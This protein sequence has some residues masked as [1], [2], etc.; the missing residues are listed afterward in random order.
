MIKVVRQKG[1]YSVH[2]P[3]GLD[4]YISRRLLKHETY[5]VVMIIAHSLDSVSDRKE[6]T[7]R[8]LLDDWL[9]QCVC[10]LERHQS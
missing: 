10:L 8:S 6:G 3:R 5:T 2:L 1:I 7:E 9:L 4:C